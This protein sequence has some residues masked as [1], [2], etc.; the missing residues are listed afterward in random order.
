MKTAVC[1]M[2]GTERELSKAKVDVTGMPSG[3]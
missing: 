2:Q 1:V 3:L